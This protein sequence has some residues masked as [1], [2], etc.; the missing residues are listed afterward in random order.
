MAWSALL[1][2]DSSWLYLSHEQHITRLEE[3]VLSS[4]LLCLG[5][6]QNLV[7]QTGNESSANFDPHQRLLVGFHQIGGQSLATT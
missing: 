7:C 6:T 3:A 2:N 5:V 4:V 1:S